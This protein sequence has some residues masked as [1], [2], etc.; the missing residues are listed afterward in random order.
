MDNRFSKIAETTRTAGL[1]A[2]VSL[3]LSVGGCSTINTIKSLRSG[4]ASSPAPL[5]YT[6]VSAPATQPPP[7]DA[8]PEPPPPATGDSVDSIVASVDGEPIT[9]HDVKVF[10]ASNAAAATQAGGAAPSVP[11]DPQA[12]LKELIVQ[13]LLQQESQKYADR[14][15]DEEIDHYIEA[16]KQKGNITEDQLRAQLQ[17]QGVTYD[18]FR[19]TVRKQVQAMAMID[20]E[21]RQKILITDAQVEAYYKEHPDEFTIT[22]EKYQLA[23]ILI[24]VPANSPPDQVEAARKKAEDLHKKAVTGADFGDLAR[25]FSDDDSKSKGGELG[26]F[27]PS[28]LNDSIAAAVA[29]LKAGDISD[30]VRTQYG[31]HIIKVEAHQKPGSQSLADV[32]PQIR[33]KLLTE[34]AK[35][36]FQKWVD[37]DLV[38]QHYVVTY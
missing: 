9:S 14:V 13:R 25:Q 35:G 5:P 15:T 24:A 8:E 7:V 32:K 33:E 11:E 16:M 22:T 23:Q 2:A 31:F 19:N 27:S 4:A 12:V 37:R 21:V 17:S 28:E 18:E 1:I 20:K 29:K 30:V 36:E 26:E 10:S 6:V 38:K 3:A 34:A